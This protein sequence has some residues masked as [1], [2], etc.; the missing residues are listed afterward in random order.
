MF[1]FEEE[2]KK[3]P[4]NPGIYIMKNDKGE[5]IYVGKAKIYLIE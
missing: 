3:L 1:N 4:K 2:I 5:I